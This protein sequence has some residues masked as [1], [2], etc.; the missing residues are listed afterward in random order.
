[1]AGEQCWVEITAPSSILLQF[2][3]N[4]SESVRM[5]QESNFSKSLCMLLILILHQTLCINNSQ[6]LVFTEIAAKQF[7]R[8]KL[9]NGTAVEVK[10]N[11][12][13]YLVSESNHGAFNPTKSTQN[14]HI[15]GNEGNA[16]R[17]T[18]SATGSSFVVSQILLDFSGELAHCVTVNAT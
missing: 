3:H 13:F 7:F 5:L 10:S 6:W 15:S 4:A 14:D 8:I 12:L 9:S 16:A 17:Q 2:E 18:F 11:L 1:M